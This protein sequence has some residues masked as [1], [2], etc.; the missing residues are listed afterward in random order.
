MNVPVS[1]FSLR[2]ELGFESEFAGTRH[3]QR[4]G[5]ILEALRLQQHSMLPG[6]KLEDGGRVANEFSIDVD[7]GGVRIRG[8]RDDAETVGD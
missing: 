2:A 4:A 3:F 8:N 7:F 1:G 5:I 6:G